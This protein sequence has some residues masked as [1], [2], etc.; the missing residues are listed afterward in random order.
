[1]RNEVLLKTH[2]HL[3]DVSREFLLYALSM[4][5]TICGCA[6]RA[7]IKIENAAAMTLLLCENEF[8]I[9]A[10]C[11]RT[12][13]ERIFTKAYLMKTL[14]SNESNCLSDNARIFW[15]QINSTL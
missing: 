1:M 14:L 4:Y 15:H 13:R 9:L 10:S 8:R 12:L 7:R 2:Y 11:L 3:S 6:T 5:S